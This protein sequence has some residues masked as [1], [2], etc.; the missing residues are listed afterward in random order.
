MPTNCPIFWS[1]FRNHRKDPGD[2][3]S[4]HERDRDVAATTSQPGI[5]RALA[6]GPSAEV[7]LSSHVRWTV[8]PTGLG[9]AP[10]AIWLWIRREGVQRINRAGIGEWENEGG[11]LALAAGTPG[12]LPVAGPG[13]RSG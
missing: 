5:T 12:F 8:L 2:P 1:L 13:R 3:R 11:K 10:V 6:H 7:D 4:R 9:G